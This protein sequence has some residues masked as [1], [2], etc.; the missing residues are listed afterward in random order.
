[1][2]STRTGLRA[3]RLAAMHEQK[4]ERANKQGRFVMDRRTVTAA[5][6]AALAFLFGAAGMAG[7][8]EASAADA[9]AKATAAM[10]D[11][12]G[13]SVGTVAFEQGAQGT[14]VHARLTDLPPGAHALHV[15][16]TGKCE[17]PAFTSAGG[18]YNPSDQAHGFFADDGYHA[19]DLPNFHVP[20]SGTVEIEFFSEQLKLDDNVFD[21][22]GSSVVIHAG[23]DDYRTDPAGDAGGRVACGVIERD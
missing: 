17:A 13:N 9:A 5:S 8:K 14:V 1:M 15:H 7:A 2:P 22:D 6:A 16:E 20:D 11:A 4:L 3:D 21:S 18:H 19:G 12:E 23:M 10:K